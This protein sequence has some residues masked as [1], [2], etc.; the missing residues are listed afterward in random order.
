MKHFNHPIGDTEEM[1]KEY[2]QNRHL[3][4]DCSTHPNLRT[5]RET[6][7]ADCIFGLLNQAHLVS[8]AL[9]SE[10]DSPQK[11]RLQLTVITTVKSNDP[12]LIHE[13]T[14]QFVLDEY[15]AALEELIGLFEGNKIKYVF[16]VNPNA[17]ARYTATI[18]AEF[19][20]KLPIVQ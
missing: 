14:E 9:S 17:S 11:H 2:R 18:I 4:R 7:A 1:R 15:E 8:N 12:T 3:L 10:L 5:I 20:E 19:E 16:G 13:T 6:V